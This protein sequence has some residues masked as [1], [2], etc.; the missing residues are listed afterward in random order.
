MSVE[1]SDRG[2]VHQVDTDS[3]LFDNTCCVHC[4]GDMAGNNCQV[5]FLH[6]DNS[7]LP[8]MMMQKISRKKLSVGTKLA[9]RLNLDLNM[10]VLA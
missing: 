6:S 2:I 8:R 1:C 10:N 5:E 7:K 3:H 9:L 4:R